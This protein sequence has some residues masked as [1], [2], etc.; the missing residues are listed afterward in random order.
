MINNNQEM[1][2]LVNL[3]SLI[4]VQQSPEGE[5]MKPLLESKIAEQLKELDAHRGYTFAFDAAAKEF[6]TQFRNENG[7]ASRSS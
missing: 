3:E 4:R 5:R 1:I 7:K 2:M 6:E